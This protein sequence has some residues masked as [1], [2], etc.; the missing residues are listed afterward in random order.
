[1]RLLF[2]AYEGYPSRF[3]K[4]LK[5][6]GLNTSLY[7]WILDF[8]T[9]VVRVGGHNS[10]IPHPGLWKEAGKEPRTEGVRGDGCCTGQQTIH[11]HTSAYL[12]IIQD[13]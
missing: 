8:L 2:I 1:M 3:V 12:Y 13:D 11:H 4:K 9:Q 5:D 7:M 10:S 6:L